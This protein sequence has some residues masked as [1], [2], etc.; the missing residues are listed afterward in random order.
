MLDMDVVKKRDGETYVIKV[1]S[2]E[3]QNQVLSSSDIEMDARARQAVKAAIEK[4][5]FCKKPVARYDIE[6]KRA[7]IEYADGVRKYVE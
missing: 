7:Y 3:E 2:P 1:V 4:A 5:E 6:T